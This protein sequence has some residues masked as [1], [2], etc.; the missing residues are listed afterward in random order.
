MGYRYVANSMSRDAFRM[1]DAL[2]TIT[3]RSTQKD[4]RILV[5]SNENIDREIDL[6]KV[7]KFQLARCLGVSIM[8]GKVDE[9]VALYNQESKLFH[10]HFTT[11]DF[12]AMYSYLSFRY[13]NGIV[14]DLITML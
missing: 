8:Q 12:A 10:L 13:W 4:K 11:G 9:S 6:S 7:L 14:R 2:K 1:Y 5:A 3:L